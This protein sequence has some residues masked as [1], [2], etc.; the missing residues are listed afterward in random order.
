MGRIKV[1]PDELRSASGELHRYGEE[2]QALGDRVNAIVGSM[3]WETRLQLHLV[4]RTNEA[5]SQARLLA[6]H[7]AELA[8]FLAQKAG[9][10]E[11][12]DQADQPVPSSKQFLGAA[13]NLVPYLPPLARMEGVSQNG[14]ERLISLG[15]LP[16]T[17][18]GDGTAAPLLPVGG[19]PLV[20]RYLRQRATPTQEALS[21]ALPGAAGLIGLGQL[22]GGRRSIV[23]EHAT[24]IPGLSVARAELKG[25]GG[26][27]LSAQFD[28]VHV[29]QT[30]A[31]GVTAH[32]GAG[33]FKAEVQAFDL[34]DAIEKKKFNAKVSA[35]ASVLHGEVNGRWGNDDLA[36]GAG[37]GGDVLGA[38]G[39][40]QA[41]TDGVEVAGYAYVAE[42]EVAGTIKVFSW[43]VKFGVRGCAACVGGG[44]KMDWAGNSGEIGLAAVLGGRVFWDI[45]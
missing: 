11:Q 45:D 19:T 34:K 14:L 5:H 33:H 42:G 15:L 8:R 32:A 23:R 20:D 7:L 2:L 39:T 24:G 13:R 31:P 28:A 17:P 37:A 35:E 9:A 26:R 22:I 12:A 40:L 25:I 18:K 1:Y 38:K 4:G 30:L 36:V 10:F 16:G 44:V 43:S 27:G 6:Q 41:G 21:V 3:S 29:E